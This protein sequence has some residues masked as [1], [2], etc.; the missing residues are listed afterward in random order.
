MP[1]ANSND[2]KRK[3]LDQLVLSPKLKAA[4]RHAGITPVTLFRWLKQSMENPTSHRLSWLGQ[5]QPF[6]LHVAAA[7][8]LSIV[9]LD[10]SARDLAINGH[11]E[12][13]FH[14]GKPVWKV[15]PQVAADAISYSDE[16]WAEGTRPGRALT[17]I[18]ATR[19]ARSFRM[20]SC[21]RRTLRSSSS[22]SR[23]SRRR[24]MAR[25]PKSTSRIKVVCGSRDRI[26]APH[27]RL[28]SKAARLRRGVRAARRQPIRSSDQITRWRCRDR[29]PTA[30]SSMRSSARSCSAK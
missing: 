10:H 16:D 3:V 21:I 14:D 4:A 7:R 24:S 28:Q 1:A 13:R 23:R 18:C 5:M 25:N 29:A 17:S 26:P 20:S 9:A 27:V 15:D 6:H 12:P 8:K 19:R 22:C 2:T 30:R 11:S